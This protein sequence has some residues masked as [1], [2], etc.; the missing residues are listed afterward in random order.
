MGGRTRRSLRRAAELCDGWMPFGL[1]GSDLAE[2][3]ESIAEGI[4]SREQCSAL[5]DMGYRLGQ[6]FLLHE[7][8]P[9][10]ELLVLLKG[11]T[12]TAWEL[13]Q[14]T[15]RASDEAAQRLSEAAVIVPSQLS[16]RGRR[17]K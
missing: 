7:P 1:R 17:R 10:D 9:F 5:K 13:G 15:D 11:S 12:N 8:M 4:E 14:R 2:F 6:G 3:R 16:Y